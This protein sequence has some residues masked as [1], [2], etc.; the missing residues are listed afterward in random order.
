[1]GDYSKE[2]YMWRDRRGRHC[3]LSIYDKSEMT[4]TGNDGCYYLL[5]DRETNDFVGIYYWCNN[6]WNFNDLSKN[7]KEYIP[8][9][10]YEDVIDCLDEKVKLLVDILLKKDEQYT[11]WVEK[12]IGKRYV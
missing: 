4:D 7:S 3:I 10:I 2:S 5:R 9:Q 6:Q 1:M 11:E 12:N 8:C